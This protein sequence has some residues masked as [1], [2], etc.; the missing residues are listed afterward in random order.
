MS[1]ARWPY[2]AARVSTNSTS[3]VAGMSSG[4][5]GEGYIAARLLRRPAEQPSV[6]GF[7]EHVSLHRLEHL[8][9]RLERVGPW[10]HVEL[11]V[12]RVDLEHVVMARARRGRA[13]AAVHL[14]RRAVLVAPVRQFL[15]FRLAFGHTCRRRRNVPDDPM[16]LIL[17]RLVAGDVEVTHV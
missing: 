10:R 8:R 9:A 13:R 14:S 17:G 1:A 4:A 5:C 12:E 7:A 11:R 16:R 2:V 15:A 6:N 3:G